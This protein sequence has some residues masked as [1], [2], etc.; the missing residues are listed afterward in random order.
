MHLPLFAQAVLHGRWQGLLRAPCQWQASPRATSVQSAQGAQII[1]K[2][3]WLAFSMIDRDEKRRLLSGHQRPLLAH[4][5]FPRRRT[6]PAA[7]RATSVPQ[8]ARSYVKAQHA[9]DQTEREIEA[10]QRLH[11]G[12]AQDGHGSGHLNPPSYLPDPL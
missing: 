1:W 7:G 11:H 12:P 9:R 6:A 2:G 8:L 3:P 10:R 5:F 4:R